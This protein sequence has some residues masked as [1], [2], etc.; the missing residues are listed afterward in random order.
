MWYSPKLARRTSIFLLVA[1]TL[2]VISPLFTASIVLAQEAETGSETVVVESTTSSASSSVASSESSATSVSSASSSATS[3]SESSSSS[4]ESST[5]SS[6]SESSS[7]SITSSATSSESSSETSAASSSASSTISAESIDSEGSDP[8]AAMFAPV[9]SCPAQAELNGT[10]YATIQAAIDA[11]EANP[12]ADTINVANGTYNECLTINGS[13]IT[14][15]GES[16]GGVVI[17]TSACSGY[18]FHIGSSGISNI[19]LDNF[20]LVGPTGAGSAKYGFK[21]EG[22]TNITLDNITVQNSNKSN[23]D[24]NGVN[25]VTISDLTTTGTV[26][27]NGLAFTD[28]NNV[29][30]TNLTAGGN[31]WASVAVYSRGAYSYPEGSENYTFSGNLDL[32]DAIGLLVQEVDT[33]T[34][35]HALSGEISGIAITSGANL[36]NSSAANLIVLQSSN[37]LTATGVNFGTSDWNTVETKITHDCTNSTFA[38]GSCNGTDLGSAYGSVNYI[39]NSAPTIANFSVR[40]VNNLWGSGHELYGQYAHYIGSRLVIGKTVTIAADFQDADDNLLTTRM[41]VHPTWF[42]QTSSWSG[43]PEGVDSFEW[44]TEGNTSPVFNAPDGIYRVLFSAQDGY[45]PTIFNNVATEFEVIVDNTAP[46]A[47]YA[48]SVPAHGSTVSGTINI[49]A[50]FADNNVDGLYRV[51]IGIHGVVWNCN[52]GPSSHTDTTVFANGTYNCNIDTTTLTN[53]TYQISIGAIDKAGNQVVAF[54]REIVVNNIS[55]ETL[56]MCKQDK[57]GNPLSGWNLGLSQYVSQA[58]VAVDG[59]TTTIGG[60]TAGK[61]YV[62]VA[63]GTYRYGNAQMI[64]D[65]GYSYRPAGIPGGNN[66]WVSGD[67]LGNISPVWT[68]ALEVKVD[69]ANVAWEPFNNNHVYA[70]TFTATDSDFGFSIFDDGYSDNLTTAGDPLRVE[71]YEVITSGTTDADGCFDV[72]VMPGDYTAFEVMQNDYAFDSLKLGGSAVSA[73]NG[74]GNVTITTGGSNNITFANRETVV[75]VVTLTQPQVNEIVT[76]DNWSDVLAQVAVATQSEEITNFVCSLDASETLPATFETNPFLNVTCTFEDMSGN[77]G[78]A[79]TQV[80]VKDVV[81][82]VTISGDTTLLAGATT[83]LTANASGGN[84]DLTYAWVCS[85]GNVSGAD[86]ATLTF[87][88]NVSGNFNCEVTV[89]DA[90]GDTATANVAITVKPTATLNTPTVSEIV[91]SSN[92][93]AALALVTV[94]S[95]SEAV[96]NLNCSLDASEV[97]PATFENNPSLTVNCTF[98]SVDSGVTGSATTTISVTNLVPEVSITGNTNIV[99]GESTV[100]TA[101]ATSGNPAYDYAWACTPTGGTLTNA[102]TAALTFSSTVSGNYNC[103]VTVADSDGDIATANIDIVVAPTATLNSPTTNEIVTTDN[104]STVLGLVAV[105]SSSEDVTNLSCVLADGETLPATFETNPVLDV[106]CTF[107]S[108][109]TGINGSATTTITL[110]DVEPI[111]VS[112]SGATT[113]A[114]GSSTVLTANVSGGNPDL[115]YSWECSPAA[116]ILSGTNTA[117]LTIGNTTSGTFEC[118]VTVTDADGDSDVDENILVTVTPV[119]TFSAPTVSEIVN[120]SNIGTTTTGTLGLITVTSQSEP[121]DSINC[122]LDGSESLPA[123]FETNPVLNVTCTFNSVGSNID[124]SATTQINVVDLVPT[125]SISGDLSIV[126]GASTTLTANITSAGNPNYTYAWSC[127]NTTPNQTGTGVSITASNDSNFS[128]SVTV[129]DFDGDT[130]TTFVTVFVGQTPDNGGNPGGGDGNNPPVGQG[131]EVLGENTTSTP[132]TG[133]ETE[134]PGSVQGAQTCTQTVGIGGHVFFDSNANMSLDNGEQPATRVK[135]EIYGRDTDGKEVLITTV[136]SNDQGEWR[137]SIC[138]G[139]YRF[140]IVESS[141][142]QNS[143]LVSGVDQRIT[144]ES[145]GRE[146]I[147]FVLIVPASFNWA[148]I[149]ILILVLLILFFILWWYR[150]RQQEKRHNFHG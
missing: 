1:V 137:E 92:I 90:D 48:A 79:T 75:P 122:T 138:P 67:E 102:D 15:S 115:T 150:R 85:G 128:C 83:T 2:Q 111:I 38:H 12:G 141:L 104:L 70:K 72:S 119:A 88:N 23:V 25:N 106:E 124:G 117:S 130:A 17:N 14:L 123:T 21:I 96:T 6:S 29:T 8:I 149:V 145:N 101:T 32:D 36:S 146:N 69:G 132:S 34:G 37:N 100:L 139:T 40:G 108:V 116:S 42:K 127:D 126:A 50:D 18:G 44:N 113:V 144:V 7:S 133:S 107:E 105:T 45:N 43:I 86:T 11:A 148:P 63:K 60:L 109:A 103:V 98:D 91:D 84:P 142:P 82:S 147:N 24:F 74:I 80:E 71:V 129:T 31:A 57:L 39:V 136:T 5:A 9:A 49:E 56:A 112:V 66:S 134:E 118:T 97:L 143:S 77:A 62:V 68:G 3:S 87:G 93:G 51:M 78:S 110:A 41:G 35:T 121:I 27:G 64:A 26:S 95:S 131:G 4:S 46:T 76:I 10:C 58:N 135:V 65:A 125:V 53:G 13:D 33:A 54:D 99:A 140:T 52:I 89:T 59:S 20:T 55:P 19:N 28:T 73:A 47:A 81:P 61:Q 22:V 30:V 16:Q 94:Q 120:S 114:A